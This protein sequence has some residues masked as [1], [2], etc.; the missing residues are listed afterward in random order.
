ATEILSKAR[1]LQRSIEVDQQMFCIF[2]GGDQ[3]FSKGW[4]SKPRK[5]AEALRAE[6]KAVLRPYAQLTD[7]VAAAPGPAVLPALDGKPPAQL[8]PVKPTAGAEAA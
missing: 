6:V 7:G 5:E 8:P 4:G 3:Y 2:H 1:K